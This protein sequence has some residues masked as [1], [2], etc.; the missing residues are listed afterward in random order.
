[1]SPLATPPVTQL[2]A[3]VIGLDVMACGRASAPAI[4]QRQQ[5]RLAQ[6]LAAAAAHTR[7]YREALQGHDPKSKVYYKNIWV[8]AL[9]E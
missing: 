3:A 5:Q 4:A 9:P 6:L 1:M 2:S 8:K 7:F